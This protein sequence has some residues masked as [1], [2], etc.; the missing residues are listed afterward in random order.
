MLGHS[1]GYF[2]FYLRVLPV[3][4]QLGTF[5]NEGLRDWLNLFTIMR[6]H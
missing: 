1:A 6:F 4:I 2:D 5:Y 3:L